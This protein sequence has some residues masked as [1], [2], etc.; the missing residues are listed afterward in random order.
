MLST[1]TKNLQNKTVLK[2][3][4]IPNVIL[5]VKNPQE[6][7]PARCKFYSGDWQNYIIKDADGPKF[8]QILTSETIYNPKNY[9]KILNVFKSKLKEDG[10]V[11]LAAKTLYF[12]VGGSL[13]QFE[14]AVKDYGT[15]QSKVIYVKKENVP[16]E[17]LEIKFLTK[18]DQ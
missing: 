10:V 16:R 6:T 2:H 9:Q 1:N 7:I 13:R 4:T 12:G 8:D 14:A 3:I 5:N 17:I 15:F 18:N 11:Y